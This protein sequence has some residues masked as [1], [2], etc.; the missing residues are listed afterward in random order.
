MFLLLEH[1]IWECG[2]P[3]PLDP[4]LPLHAWAFVETE[5]SQNLKEFL[6]LQLE[7]SQSFQLLKL[8]CQDIYVQVHV[9]V[10][11]KE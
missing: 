8:T 5:K 11:L 4:I 2:N 3:F 1:C 10:V 6:K 9:Y 7:F